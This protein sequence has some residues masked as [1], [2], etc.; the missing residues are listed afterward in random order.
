[1]HHVCVV[2]TKEGPSTLLA[3]WLAPLGGGAGKASVMQCMMGFLGGVVWMVGTLVGV[4]EIVK[5]HCE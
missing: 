2:K 1:M 4:R 3:M 5:A